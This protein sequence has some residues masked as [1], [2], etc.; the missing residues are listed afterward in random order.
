MLETFKGG[1]GKKA[2]YATEMRRV[3]SPL[4][5]LVEKLAADYKEL[6][7]EYYD[8]SDERLLTRV[9][10][11]LTA[12]FLEQIENL[13]QENDELQSKNLELEKEATEMREAMQNLTQTCKYWQEKAAI[14]EAESAHLLDDLAATA[15]KLEEQQEKK[16]TAE[17]ERQF[18][19][20]P[21]RSTITDA[22]IIMLL[23]EAL[24]LRA[25]A[26]GAIKRKIEQ[27]LVLLTSR[28]T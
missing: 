10:Q 7:Q 6:V 9:S 21:E 17:T 3:P 16:E 28:E 5:M 23:R 11:G 1:R 2:P 25:N 22:K 4:K 14:T 27:A 19:S 15:L 8:P 13:S 12:T 18:H 24:K 26:G 20:Q